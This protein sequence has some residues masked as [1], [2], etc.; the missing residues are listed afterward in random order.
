MVDA[1]ARVIVRVWLGPF[2][3]LLVIVML[4][5]FGV[6]LVM[7]MLGNRADDVVLGNVPLPMP[8]SMIGLFS[9]TSM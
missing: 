7:V 8:G 2:G 3:V 1:G 6:L 9:Y 5:K 4:G